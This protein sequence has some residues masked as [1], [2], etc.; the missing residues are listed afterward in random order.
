MK[1]Q[2]RKRLKEEKYQNMLRSRKI[3]LALVFECHTPNVRNS[4]FRLFWRETLR[5]LDL[6]VPAH[7][8]THLY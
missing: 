3:K 8:I 2:S 7:E 5:S 4:K 6:S 1:T